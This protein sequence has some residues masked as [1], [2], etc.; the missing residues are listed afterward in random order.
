MEKDIKKILLIMGHSAGIGDMLRASASWR[1]LKNKFPTADLH[2]LFLTKD[3]G[4]VSETLISKHHLLA[5]FHT[6]DKRLKSLKDWIEFFKGFDK[7]VKGPQGSL[8]Q[9][10]FKKQ[11]LYRQVFCSSKSLWY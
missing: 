3:P 7:L 1:A 11:R 8:Q 4:Y 5:S 2:L 9:N 6:L 10:R